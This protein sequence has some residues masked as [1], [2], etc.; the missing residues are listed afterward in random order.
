[1]SSLATRLRVSGPQQF[2]LLAV[3]VLIP[4]FQWQQ[5][6]LLP[7]MP[8][9][10]ITQTFMAEVAPRILGICLLLALGH[11][12]LEHWLRHRPLPQRHGAT[13]FNFSIAAYTILFGFT[14]LLLILQKRPQSLSAPQRLTLGFSC[15]GGLTGPSLGAVGFPLYQLLLANLLLPLVLTALL[16]PRFGGRAAF[17]N[18]CLAW[19]REPRCLSGA[20][21]ICWGA[22]S[23]SS[24]R[25][26]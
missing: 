13:R 5:D 15:A 4:L 23:G 12:V 8:E 9:L 17:L 25:R 2:Q 16:L 26:W 24:T 21:T 14:K 22:E 20:K 1:M 11:H 19:V 6:Q 7:A 10:K 3:W 18:P